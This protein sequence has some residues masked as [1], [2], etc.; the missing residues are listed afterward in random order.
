[1]VFFQKTNTDQL[2]IFSFY[3]DTKSESWLFATDLFVKLLALC[4]EFNITLVQTKLSLSF[5]FPYDNTIPIQK[6]LC[7]LRYR[8]Y[9]NIYISTLSD[10]KLIFHLHE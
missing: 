6:G 5:T 10:T 4:A 3:Q 1:M 8:G 2:I 9:R 7:V